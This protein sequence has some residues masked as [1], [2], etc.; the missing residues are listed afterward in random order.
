MACGGY[1]GQRIQKLAKHCTGSYVASAPVDNLNLG[2]HPYAKVMLAT[3]PRRVTRRDVG[4]HG[5]LADGSPG[6]VMDYYRNASDTNADSLG[7]CGELGGPDQAIGCTLPPLP[8][9]P[10]CPDEEDPFGH[11]FALV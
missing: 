4:L 3:Q 5:C 9:A 6:A 7:D 2:L 11:G 1:S 10:A 8:S